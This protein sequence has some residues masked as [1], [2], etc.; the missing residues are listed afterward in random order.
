MLSFPDQSQSFAYGVE[1]GRL[2]QKIEQGDDVIINNGFPIRL[3]NKE[4][5][6]NTCHLYGYTPS[7]GKT[8]WGEWIEFLAIRKYSNEN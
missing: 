4:L 5:I 8:Y 1:F 6:E 3:E 2:L 7:F